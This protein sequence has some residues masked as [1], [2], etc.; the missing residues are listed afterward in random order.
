MS[1][2]DITQRAEAVCNRFWNCQTSEYAVFLRYISAALRA[3]RDETISECR[4]AIDKVR[5]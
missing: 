2:Q 3:M 4:A 5:Q 1:E